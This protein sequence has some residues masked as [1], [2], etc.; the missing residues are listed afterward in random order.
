MTGIVFFFCVCVFAAHTVIDYFNVANPGKFFIGLN[1]KRTTTT[2][3]LW[4]QLL[5][6]M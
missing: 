6:D 5:C 1:P 4:L 3:D 2:I